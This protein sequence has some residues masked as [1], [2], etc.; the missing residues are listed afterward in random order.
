MILLES[1]G[2]VFQFKRPASNLRR[3]CVL[4]FSGLKPFLPGRSQ[5][6]AARPVQ[7]VCFYAERSLL[8]GWRQEER[9][10]HG[11]P[12]ACI[13]T[14]SSCRDLQHTSAVVVD[15]G[16]Q[17]AVKRVFLPVF[18]GNV[19]THPGPAGGGIAD[20]GVDVYR[21]GIRKYEPVPVVSIFPLIRI[22]K[23]L[24]VLGKQRVRVVRIQHICR[25]REAVHSA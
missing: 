16:N 18:E 5:R 24:G 21:E 23:R 25:K 6:L 11:G 19:Q 17:C 1:C 3:A 8:L 22:G 15:S 14:G 7:P 9:Q 20:R 10:A 12:R 4:P 2:P 13:Q